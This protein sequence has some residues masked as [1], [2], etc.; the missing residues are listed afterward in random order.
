MSEAIRLRTMARKSVF[1]IGKLEGLSVQQA[2]NLKLYGVLRWYYYN[3]SM[4]SFLPEI[5]D[6]LG[7]T[8]EWRIEKPGTDLDAYERFRE[9]KEKS[10]NALLAN[11]SETDKG[12]AIGL[13]KRQERI[14]RGKAM[15][16]LVRFERED[17]K[18]FTKGNMQRRNH[19]H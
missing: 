14:K 1:S 5:L 2:L 18:S 11:I 13:R 19:G 4:V 17:A 8:D 3:C 9:W 12:K 16:R 7:I 10:F 6:E 15:A